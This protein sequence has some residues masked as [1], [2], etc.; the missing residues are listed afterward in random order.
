[1]AKLAAYR[2][3]LLSTLSK[4]QSHKKVLAFMAANGLRQLGEPRIG[5]YANLQRPEPMH[6]EINAWQHNLNLIYKEALQRNC[7]DLF[8]EVLRS[9]VKIVENSVPTPVSPVTTDVVSQAEI[10][11]QSG[12]GLPF[13]ANRIREHYNDKSHKANNLSVR[14]IGRQAIALAK[15]S[16]KLIDALQ[17]VDESEAQKLKKLAL[18]KAAEYLRNAGTLFNKVVT[19]ILEITQLKDYLMKY[20]NILALF[21]PASVNITVWTMAYAIPYHSLL[22]F[23]NYGVGLGIISL[24]AKESK[25]SAIKHDLTLTNR[26]KSTGSLGKLWQVMRANYVRAFYL[27]EHHP[28]PSTYISHYESRMPSQITKPDYCDCGR[29]KDDPHEQL[30]SFCVQCITILHCASEQQLVAEVEEVLLPVV[31]SLCKMRFPDN[32]VHDDH[33]NCIHTRGVTTLSNIDIKALT[34]SE[35]KE[36]LKRRGLTISGTK[37]ILRKRLEGRVAGETS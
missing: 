20:F 3:T 10:V 29:E 5:D 33:V 26:S 28:M 2:K 11:N 7:I 34:V 21:F 27:P 19:N 36:E 35:L 32:S 12:C 22:L 9:P 24:Q 8:L 23:E 15:H 14:L 17:I 16:H 13:I 25:H 37:D 1:M 4:T 31:C 18:G 30:C 6:H